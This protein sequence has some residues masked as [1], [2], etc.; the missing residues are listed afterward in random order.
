M[1]DFQRLIDEL[2]E[3]GYENE[4]FD[5]NAKDTI[6]HSFPNAIAQNRKRTFLLSKWA[7]KN[8]F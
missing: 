7:F 1:A 6:S 3:I 4:W 8:T 5:L 2:K